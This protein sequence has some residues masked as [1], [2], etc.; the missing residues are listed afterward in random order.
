MIV[1]VE[2]PSAAGMTTWALLH[3]GSALIPEDQPTTVPPSE[4]TAAAAFWVALDA[5][6]WAR[7]VEVRAVPASPCS[8]PTH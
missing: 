6:R 2:G 3:A 1:V 4:P 7:G 5:Q 8:I